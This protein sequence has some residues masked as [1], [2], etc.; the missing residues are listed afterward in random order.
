[1]TQS[2]APT[3]TPTQTSPPADARRDFNFVAALVILSVS[4]GILDAVSY[5]ALDQVFTGNMTGNV[6][7]LGFAF[8]GLE[9]LPVL[10][11]LVALLAFF[12]GAIVAAGVL[13]LS[14]TPRRV[15]L[16]TIWM[17]AGGTILTL[18]VGV[19]WGLSGALDKLGLVVVTGVLAFALGAQSSSLKPVGIKDIS[20]VVVTMTMVNLAGDGWL[21]G[22]KDPHWLRKVLAIAAM[23]AG[24]Y[25]GAVL[26]FH[27]GGAIAVCAAAVVMSIGIIT[28]SVASKR[29][30]R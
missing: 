17:M 10:N 22:K 14:S 6:L 15:P 7:F 8:A 25:L 26:V 13:R 9:Q 30:L 2:I 24:A 28:L 12:V 29:S 20:T 1:M 4:T 27:F 3:S 19:V 5:L 21:A 11:L 18:T 23:G 16:A